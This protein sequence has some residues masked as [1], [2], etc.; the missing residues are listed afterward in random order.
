MTTHSTA[1]LVTTLAQMTEGNVKGAHN[2]PRYQGLILT[3]GSR[4]CVC[5]DRDTI[6][7]APPIGHRAEPNV[8]SV[9]QRISETV[10]FGAFVLFSDRSSS[11][12]VMS[13]LTSHKRGLGQISGKKARF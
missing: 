11:V 6:T 9:D 5:K 13:R 1:S 8:A 3:L 2:T 4:S 10:L 7:S 12:C